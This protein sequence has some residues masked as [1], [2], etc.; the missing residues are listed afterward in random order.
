MLA[1]DA[2]VSA[3]TFPSIPTRAMVSSDR[4]VSV[5]GAASFSDGSADKGTAQEPGATY[6]HLGRDAQHR[7]HAT[8]KRDTRGVER[9]EHRSGI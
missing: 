6:A 9:I 5:M 2:F 7:R 4:P 8:R 1:K 3:H